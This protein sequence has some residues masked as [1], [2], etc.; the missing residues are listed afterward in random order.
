M[1]IV[2]FACVSCSLVSFRSLV[3]KKLVEGSISSES[4]SWRAEKPPCY[5]RVMNGEMQVDGMADEVLVREV[6]AV[7]AR[8]NR[9]T[10]RLLV[11]LAEVERRDL[12][13]KEGRSS[14]FAYCVERLGMA[15]GAAYKRVWAARVGRRFP[16]VLAMIARGE[17][18]LTGV[19]LLARHL[20]EE[21]HAEL[22]ARAR[23][24]TKRE[25][26]KLVA[27][28]APRADVPSRVAA[29]PVRAVRS[30][31]T[32]QMPVAGDCSI[33]PPALAAGDVGG[34]SGGGHL[35][36]GAPRLAPS[37]DRPAL[38]QPLAPRRYQV[39]VTVGEEAH[40]A[41]RQ[42]QDLMAHEIPDGDPAVIVERALALLLE[43]KLARKAALTRRPRPVSSRVDT[44]ARG[45]G[46][47]AHR[48]R[49]VPAEIRRAVWER[50][51]GRCA[52]VDGEG[53]RCSARRMLEFHHVESWA[54]GGAHSTDN[55]ELRCRAH[56]QHQANLDHGADFMESR[57]PDRARE[58]RALY[59]GRPSRRRPTERARWG[60]AR[61]RARSSSERP[62]HQLA[63]RVV[64]ARRR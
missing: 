57:R 62:I 61:S 50:D 36:D 26:E 35:G 30:T 64:V 4:A 46:A 3:A 10:A 9:L 22:L 15:E 29:L 44:G 42:L 2:A 20:T 5:V 38:V 53:R 13:L 24:R 48:S 32:L 51:E 25:I 43:K 28:I 58:V 17:I 18:H 45:E 8:G 55:I 39:R 60:S 34:S 14:L 27:E 33:S 31:S 19:H 49:H 37:I 12:H 16:L 59:S 23:G 6:A 56:N 7:V 11:V 41:L 54:R 21:N 40:A 47:A 52:H 63:P 1:V